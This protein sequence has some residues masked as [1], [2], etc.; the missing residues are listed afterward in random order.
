M[1]T[2]QLKIWE[3]GWVELKTE[4][5]QF[6]IGLSKRATGYLRILTPHVRMPQKTLRQKHCHKEKLTFN[7]SVLAEIKTKHR[8]LRKQRDK[9]AICK[10]FSSGFLWKYKLMNKLN[11]ETGIWVRTNYLTNHLLLWKKTIT[12]FFERDDNNVMTA[13]KRDTITTGKVKK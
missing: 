9:L 4:L 10:V 7:A 6:R 8:S 1:H 11:Q 3:S 12:Y 13:G 5:K 2:E